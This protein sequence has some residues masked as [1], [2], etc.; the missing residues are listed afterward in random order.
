MEEQLTCLHCHK[1]LDI[2]EWVSTDNYAGEICCSK[3]NARLAIT[4]KGSSKPIRYKLV[5]KPTFNL[6][7]YQEKL[8]KLLERRANN[9]DE[10]A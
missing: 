10:S 8:K 9:M 6:P 7:D 3:C 1:R 4:F 5:E 2:P